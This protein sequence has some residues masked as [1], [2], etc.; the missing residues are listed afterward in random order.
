MINLS[1]NL[2]LKYSKNLSLLE[3]NNKNK[4]LSNSNSSSRI[5]K[6]Q[7]KNANYV[8]Y[9]YNNPNFCINCGKVIPI[10]RKNKYSEYKKDFFC[11]DICKKGYFTKTEIELTRRNCIKC[12]FDALSALVSGDMELFDFHFNQLK[13][14]LI[15]YSN[16]ID[17]FEF[18]NE[19]S[20]REFL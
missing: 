5:K 9:Y 2:K 20:K 11:S 10:G 3:E 18:K 15:N 8:N 12:F 1:K 16:E 17:D 6:E 4:K 19:G 7:K 13:P 14:M